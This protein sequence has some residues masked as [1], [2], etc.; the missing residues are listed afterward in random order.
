M[1]KN[2][3]GDIMS[4]KI[5]RPPKSAD[6]GDTKDKIIAATVELIKK[7]GADNITVRNV[8][9]AADISIGT[10]YHHFQ[11]KDDLLIYFVRE[12]SFDSFPLEAP[13]ENISDRV[14]ELYM[15]LI[16]RYMELGE[17]FMKSF[18]T[19]GNRALS[20]YMGEE[21]G[22]FLSGSVMARCEQEIQD[23]IQSGILK[24]KIN[25]HIA[26]VDVCT[27]IKGCVFEWSLSSGAM[28]I[29]SSV[30]RI[31]RNYFFGLCQI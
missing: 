12:Q 28:D 30:Y 19:T 26:S 16:D 22:K 20:A 2:D 10:F 13:L 29:E 27:I 25:A 17:Q 8:C 3:L 24:E 1:F 21:D 4:G 18:Y 15:Y 31:V 5:G 23:A 7:Y 11:N 9:E 6:H 14:C